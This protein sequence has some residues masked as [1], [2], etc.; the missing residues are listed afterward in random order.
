[1]RFR[2]LL[3][4]LTLFCATPA[5]AERANPTQTTEWT[6]IKDSSTL[7]FEAVQMGASFDGS[8]KVFDGR[9]TFDPANLPASKADI[10]ITMDSVDA[11]S[12]DR[13]KYLPMPDWFNTDS[14]PDAHFV[15]TSITKGLDKNQYVAK[16]TLTIRDV[17][18]PILLPFILDITKSDSGGEIAKMQGEAIVNRLDYG[19][20][21]GEWKD[22]KSVENQVK[23]KVSIT[24]QKK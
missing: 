9:I 18:L 4:T 12:S 20:G 5:F 14:F 13:N 24:A 16:G 17:T 7:G 19:V 3:L 1:M 2:T 21:Q 22:T 10:T 23:I 8:F 11:G 6:I 15:T